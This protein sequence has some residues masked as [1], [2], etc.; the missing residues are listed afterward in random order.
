MK[1]IIFFFAT[2]LFV[3]ETSKAQ[4]SLHLSTPGPSHQKYREPN[5]QRFSSEYYMN[6]SRKMKTAGWILI[7]AGAVMGVTGYLVYQNQLYSNSGGLDT[8]IGNTFGS[9]FLSV[10][11][12][13]VVVVGVP[14]LI[15]SGY[16]KR[17]ALNMSAMLK[18][19]P[20]QTGISM[21]QFPAVG[22]RIQL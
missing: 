8:Q 22:L 16:Y 14:V 10:A 6:K 15:R 7:S 12:A 2:L 18:F 4:D 1:Q 21:K 11:G 3:M 9:L 17:K 20:N 5:G 19:E 13:A